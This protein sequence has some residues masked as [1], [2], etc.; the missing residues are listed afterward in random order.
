MEKHLKI[1]LSAAKRVAFLVIVSF[2]LL[3]LVTTLQAQS[4]PIAQININESYSLNVTKISV[5]PNPTVDKLTLEI[6]EFSGE[7]FSIT[8][9]NS[10]GVLLDSRN[11]VARGDKT[12]VEWS[13]VKYSP[14]S[15]FIAVRSQSTQKFYHI[16]KE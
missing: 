13:M 3:V 1:T 12:L 6:T 16:V 9:S 8:L 4:E 2:M 11:L 7:L 5:Y 10:A 14:G 15:Y